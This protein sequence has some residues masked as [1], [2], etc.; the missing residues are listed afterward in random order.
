MC[1]AV[2]KSHGGCGA[3]HSRPVVAGAPVR[4]WELNCPQCQSHLKKDP[5]WSI[6]K[7]DVPTSPDEDLARDSADKNTARSREDI[8][9]LAF[10]KMAGLPVAD[11][12]SGMLGQNASVGTVTCAAGHENFSTAKFCGECGGQLDQDS[13]PVITTAPPR[14]P[15]SIKPVKRAPRP[16][17]R[18]PARPQQRRVTAGN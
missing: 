13:V 3:S 1:I 17:G 9:A 16:D 2:S 7:A 12:L 5:L 14:D 6:T 15:A 4:L 8:M 10:A 18:S 11:F